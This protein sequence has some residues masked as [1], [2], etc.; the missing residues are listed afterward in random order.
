MCSLLL[1]C[2]HAVGF[3]FL[4]TFTHDHAMV[5][6]LQ[7]W[8][9]AGLGLGGS[10]RAYSSWECAIFFIIPALPRSFHWVLAVGYHWG[11]EDQ[12]DALFGIDIALGVMT[13]P[14]SYEGTME[15]SEQVPDSCALAEFH[16]SLLLRL[17]ALSSP[18]C[19]MAN[20]WALWNTDNGP[21]GI[22]KGVIILQT[23][24]VNF[25][26]LSRSLSC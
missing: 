26:S 22:R 20:T 17:T 4:S 1:L 7:A 13:S 24:T 14:E 9:P 12:N 6:S 21:Q 25:G 23:R 10:R 11:P 2:L 3:L 5:L 16:Q 18:V 8:G 15:L 19:Q